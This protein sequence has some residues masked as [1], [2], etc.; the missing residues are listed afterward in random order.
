MNRYKLFVC[1]FMLNYSS[2]SFAQT[3]G[4]TVVATILSPTCDVVLEVDGVAK[5][6]V[7]L[8]T[9]PANSKGVIVNIS[10]KAKD[11]AYIGC[12]NL[13]T[14]NRTAI[15]AWASAS[16]NSNGVGNQTGTAVSS[17]VELK[18]I[19]SI[20]PSKITINSNSANF[21]ANLV[22]LEGFKFS[23]QLVAGSTPGS[24]LTN[25]AFVVAYV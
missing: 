17:F 9:I 6:I 24:F 18:S 3:Q 23:V 20:T 13:V 7:Q 11:P 14:G 1:F 21:Q 16:M 15:V 12:S 5:D 4:T 8:G 19:N 2:F 22:N 10:L 25:A